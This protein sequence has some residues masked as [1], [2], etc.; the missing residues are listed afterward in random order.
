MFQFLCSPKVG[1][2]I[3]HLISFFSLPPSALERPVGM[4]CTLSEM[5]SNFCGPPIELA[6]WILAFQEQCLHMKL[7]SIKRIRKVTKTEQE[8]CLAQFIKHD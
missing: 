4:E 8:L 5:K 7:S 6:F 3:S 2:H 1:A